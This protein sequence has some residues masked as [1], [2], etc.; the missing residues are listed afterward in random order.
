[1][2]RRTL[3]AAATL[4]SLGALAAPPPAPAPAAIVLKSFHFSPA[5]LSVP[6]GT[7]VSWTNRDEEP[8]TI[9]SVDGAFRSGALD[10]DEVFR[11]TFTRAGTY[12]YVC[13]IHPQMTGTIV[14]R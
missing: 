6:L 9:A 12:R 7:T 3:L 2:R 1:M 10:A 8:H 11:Y 5:E 14:V 4:L 13:T